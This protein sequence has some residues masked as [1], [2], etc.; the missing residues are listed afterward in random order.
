MKRASLIAALIAVVLMLILGAS[1]TRGTA[2]LP[3]TPPPAAPPAPGFAVADAGAVR[4]VRTVPGNAFTPAEPVEVTLTVEYTGKEPIHALAVEEILPDG[5]SFL[6]TAGAHTPA[7]VPEEGAAGT[8]N[9]VWIQVPPMP[10]TFTYRAL[11]ATAATIVGKAIYRRSG[12]EEQSEL[13]VT[14]LKAP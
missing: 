10:L 12:G 5:W 1:L 3:K 6:S 14:E 11:P 8:L 7:I 4:L 13:C 9:F 2:P